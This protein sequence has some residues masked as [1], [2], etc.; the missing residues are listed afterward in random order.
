MAPVLGPRRTSSSSSRRRAERGGQVERR[1]FD[2]GAAQ[3]FGQLEGQPADGLL[4]VFDD[5]LID[6][7]FD[8]GVPSG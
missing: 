4:R 5:H 1:V 7:G 8:G 2:G 6:A 3:L